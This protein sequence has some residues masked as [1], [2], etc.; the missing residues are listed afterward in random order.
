MLCD[1]CDALWFEPP[2]KSAQPVSVK[3]DPPCPE[4]GEPLWN[5]SSHWADRCEV[6]DIGW[7]DRVVGE[8]GNRD[9]PGGPRTPDRVDPLEKSGE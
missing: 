3:A 6:E 7:W 5:E 1:E 8:A 9:E 2:G 4:C